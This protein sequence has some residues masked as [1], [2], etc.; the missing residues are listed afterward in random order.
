MA[1]K[2]SG[3][4]HCSVFGCT[5]NQKKLYNWNKS[6]CTIHDESHEDCPCLQPFALH[7]APTEKNVRQSW[8]A[9]LN[10]KNLSVSSKCIFV[11]SIASVPH[12]LFAVYAIISYRHSLE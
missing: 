1:Y 7:A 12:L 10:R 11:S 4:N 2:K 8:V 6:V 9:A 3:G 5:N